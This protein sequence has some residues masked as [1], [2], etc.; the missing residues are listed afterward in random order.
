M[1]AVQQ[2]T[3]KFNRA[4]FLADYYERGGW[5]GNPTGSRILIRFLTTLLYALYAEEEVA[6]KVTIQND[7]DQSEAASPQLISGDPELLAKM[8]VMTP[9]GFR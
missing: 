6:L 9:E 3:S 4:E 8:R 5:M 2:G 7:S 1:R